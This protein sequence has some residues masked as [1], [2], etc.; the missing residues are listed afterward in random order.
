M[1]GQEELPSDEVF[2]YPCPCGGT[3][4]PRKKVPLE[5]YRLPDPKYA[6]TCGGTVMLLVGEDRALKAVGIKGQSIALDI[7]H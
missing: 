1:S 2:K 4:V 3:Q 7:V 5:A 6:G